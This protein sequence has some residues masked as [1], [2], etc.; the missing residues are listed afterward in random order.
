MCVFVC[1][2]VCVCA[3]V[4]VREWGGG[5]TERERERETERERE[6]ERECMHVCVS[7]T[8][9][10][11]VCTRA[12]V[13]AYVHTCMFV[14]KNQKHKG[15]VN[16]HCVQHTRTYNQPRHHKKQPLTASTHGYWDLDARPLVS[17]W[18]VL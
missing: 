15:V 7:V 11:C 14:S 5:G 1:V 10:V 4:C 9:C 3:C 17:D 2:C 12:C 8:L 16:I 13:C 18:L 6:R